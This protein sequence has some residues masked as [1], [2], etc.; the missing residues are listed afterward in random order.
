MES[1]GAKLR[2][3][4]LARGM[5]VDEI[6]QTTKLPKGSLELLENDAYNALPALVFV[7]GFVRAYAR[8]VGLD[9]DEL[10]RQL[11]HPSGQGPEPMMEREAHFARIIG[12]GFQSERRFHPTQLMMMLAAVV[13]LFVA[14]FMGGGQSADDSEK[15][16]S[17]STQRVEKTT[18]GST[19][20]TANRDR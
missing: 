12:D 13:M 10:V 15:K 17:D 8:T 9:G 14:W 7:R 4:R 16:G 20:F 6:A 2:A 1:V 18:T 5:S 3:A 19:S 11:P